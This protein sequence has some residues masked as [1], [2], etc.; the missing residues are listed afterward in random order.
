MPFQTLPSTKCF[1]NISLPEN[2]KIYTLIKATSSGGST[3]SSSDGFFLINKSKA[4]HSIIVH[5]GIS[6]NSVV[7]DFQLTA[8]LHGQMTEISVKK[9]SL[10]TGKSF[11]LQISGTEPNLYEISSEDVIWTGNSH[12]SENML[13]KSFVPMIEHPR[14]LVTFRK[15]LNTTLLF[16]IIDCH[17]DAKFQINSK[18]Y[19][20]YWSTKSP[21]K[22][23][24]T[25]FRTGLLVQRGTTENFIFPLQTTISRERA[26]FS[27]VFLENGLTYR[28]I[29]E[30][31]FERL[32]IE[33][34]KSNGSRMQHETKALSK[35][36]S[37]LKK[38]NDDLFELILHFDGYQCSDKSY[39][40]GYA[41][42]IVDK[43]GAEISKW[44]PIKIETNMKN[45][46]TSLEN[47]SL[48]VYTQ[49]SLS[50]CVRGFC[51]SGKSA[52]SCQPIKEKENMGGNDLNN[53]YEINANSPDMEEIKSFA[54]SRYLGDK[55]RVLHDNE[56]DF[57]KSDWR[58]NGVLLGTF[59]RKISWYI[60]T[61]NR[62]PLHSCTDDVACIQEIVSEDCIGYFKQIP[63]EK[64][65]RYFVCAFA[66]K[67]IVKYEKSLEQKSQISVCGNGFIIDDTSPVP[68]KVQ[69]Q[70]DFGNFLNFN[71]S[72]SLIWEG[73]SDIERDLIMKYTSGIEKYT[74]SIGTYPG[75]ED[76]VSF[77]DTGLLTS[78]NVHNISFRNHITYYA[79]VRA[80]D[81]VGHIT[82]VSSEGVMY[83]DTPPVHG[84][85]FVDGS[86]LHGYITNYR[87]ITVTWEGFSD[88]ESGI[89]SFQIGIGSSN[90]S[91][92]I[93]PLTEAM[94][95]FWKPMKTEGKFI[96]GYEYFILLMITNNAGLS[97]LVSSLAFVIDSSPPHEGFVVDGNETGIDIDF[98]RNIT[99]I[100][101]RWDGFHDPHTELAYYEIG[102]GTT[103]DTN[104]VFPATSIGL[105]KEYCWANEFIPGEKY[106][107]IIRA[108]NKAGLCTSKSSNGVT[109]D[110][111]PPIPGLVHVG[112]S[113]RH[114][115]YISQKHVVSAQWIGFQDP[116]SDIEHFEF[117]ISKSRNDCDI[118]A[119]EN[120]LLSE[121]IT[122]TSINL[123]QNTNLYAIVKAY[124]RVGLYSQQS[125]EKFRVDTTP[126]I[127]V[128]KPVFDSAQFSHKSGT[129]YDDSVLVANWKFMEEESFIASN[130]VVLKSHKN[131]KTIRDIK[132]NGNENN[133]TIKLEDEI[134][135]KSGDTYYVFISSCNAAGLCTHASSDPLLIDSSPPQLGG[136]KNL[137]KW[138]N[139]ENKTTELLLLWHG[140]SDIHSGIEK[141]GVF[142]SES[143]TGSELSNGLLYA[144]HLDTEIQMVSLNLTRQLSETDEI[145]L[146]VYALNKVGL[147]SKIAKTTVTLVADD[148][149]YASGFLEL[150]RYLCR[151]HTCNNDCTCSVVG[152]RCQDE[153]QKPSTCK[154]NDNHA[155]MF[156]VLFGNTM[157]LTNLTLSS[158]CVFAHWKVRNITMIQRFEWSI[159]IQHEDPGAGV[160]DSRT[161][162]VWHE[163]GQLTNMT[164]CIENGKHFKHGE[165]YVFHVR[166]WISEDTYFE[167]QSNP[168]LV[169][170]TPPIIRRGKSIKETLI[171]CIENDVD[172]LNSTSNFL[173]CWEG[174]FIENGAQITKYSVSSG[175][176]PFGNDLIDDQN[177]G[178][179][180]S[181]LVEGKLLRPGVT[182][183]FTI[184]STNELGMKT[185]FTSDGVL[186]DLDN[187]TGG[188]VYNTKFHKNIA[189]QSSTSEIGLSWH[190]FDDHNS[191]IKK[192]HVALTE[193]DANETFSTVVD[194][195]I[196]NSYIFHGL[197]L[198]HN[199][200]YKVALVAF[201]AVGHFTRSSFS[202][203]QEYEEYDRHKLASVS[204]V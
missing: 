109:L 130:E 64:N 112:M 169:D 136:F 107:T 94:D 14:F 170:R 153:S 44:E 40:A 5:D 43:R 203:F 132:T 26:R 66:N 73:F 201:D 122:K 89:K 148:V 37:L 189:Y 8:S 129:Q 102:I 106:F 164:Y 159:G 61:E 154:R 115:H 190:G 80:I 91:A 150:Q 38:S 119:F 176:S 171:S 48:P 7:P 46:S 152:S 92:D 113:D 18:A 97:T 51:L 135:L 50:V 52:M 198:E 184:T 54:H 11:T 27:D 116:H 67:T 99:H 145:I 199:R 166:S 86:G 59:N 127:E 75:G 200:I 178:L 156:S 34:L 114:Q 105:L 138:K 41:V 117:C 104:D 165:S 125:S 12:F 167:K 143:Y 85:V 13:T 128:A 4:A 57:I 9:K 188:V 93:F 195:K 191:F 183:Y 15:I 90:L 55:M 168:L 19:M 179:R 47:I 42:A 82:E 71:K 72:L 192:Y 131:G 101:S 181:F 134:A 88:P 172:F 123:P 31:C 158:K 174:V 24:I 120:V 23:L 32:C 182:F 49:H 60:M 45:I 30:A 81:R 110:N 39:S 194:A 103:R 36:H 126:P 78:A 204:L 186:I 137:M 74:Y 193:K 84:R 70:T 83:D 68:G 146:S 124:N 79:T 187:P 33:P 100:C 142:V 16:K 53:V 111:S 29:I 21:Y 96:D 141:Y 62:L 133:I 196:H 20:A 151:S 65:K 121:R 95:T 76:V 163:N 28:A 69:I 118:T 160:F 197:S 139:H 202:H 180:T 175:S 77:T 87:D 2:T 185:S 147:R 22:D 10:L 144:D 140:F 157:S 25:H 98:Q 155:G 17:E 56:V 35:I 149:S 63:F 1:Y 177:V 58:I 161:E 173:V 108:C 3:I 162:S 6:C